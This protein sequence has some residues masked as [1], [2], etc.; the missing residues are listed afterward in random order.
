MRPTTKDT[1]F[2]I[3]GIAF[4]RAAA[5]NI[6]E[7]MSEDEIR[8]DVED[9]RAGRCDSTKLSSLVMDQADDDRLPGWAD[10]VH[11]IERAAA[12]PEW[13]RSST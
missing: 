13:R 1:E 4:S 11:A 10:Y 6:A 3:A 5:L 8:A 12:D 2:R 9:M 7:C